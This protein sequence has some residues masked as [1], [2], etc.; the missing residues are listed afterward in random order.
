MDVRERI[1]ELYRLGDSTKAIRRATGVSISAIRA[2]IADLP[3]RRPRLTETQLRLIACSVEPVRAVARRAHCS[4]SAVW[5]VRTNL[6]RAA[7]ADE[8]DDDDAAAI[9]FEQ[10]R[11]PRRCPRHGLRSVWPCVECA[12]EYE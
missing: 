5:H 2:A 4:K 3:R 1:R 7:D 9:M 11:K 10:L 6:A 8:T 12:A